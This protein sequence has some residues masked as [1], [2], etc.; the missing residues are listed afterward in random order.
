LHHAH[1]LEGLQLDFTTWIESL[2][3]MADLVQILA[4]LGLVTAALAYA[5]Y[6]LERHHWDQFKRQAA[7]WLDRQVALKESWPGESDRESEESLTEQRVFQEDSLTVIVEKMLSNAGFTPLQIQ[8]LL[9]T[10]LLIVRGMATDK[11]LI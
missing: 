5:R 1:K 3:P 6:Y 11:F 8:Q 4:G 7:N 2:K 10:S 9:P